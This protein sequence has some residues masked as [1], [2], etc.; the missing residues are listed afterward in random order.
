MSVDG[1]SIIGMWPII[2]SEAISSGLLT[3]GEL[4]WRYTALFPDVYVPNGTRPDR[5]VMAAG[6]WLW[7]GRTG[8]IAGTTAASLHSLGIVDSGPT[9]LIAERRRTPPGVLIRQERIDEDEVHHMGEL[10]LTSPARTAFDVARPTG[11]EVRGASNRR[12]GSCI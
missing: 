9:Q 7:T 10:P 4:R 2:G 8:T 12:G 3:R 6:A 1:V 11:T 5:F